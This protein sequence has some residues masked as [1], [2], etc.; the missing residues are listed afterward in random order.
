MRKQNITKLATLKIT[1]LP[2]FIH[3]FW[4]QQFGQKHSQ[5]TQTGTQVLSR[6]SC[7]VKDNLMCL[8]MHLVPSGENEIWR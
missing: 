6:T 7:V 3:S 1:N 5:E 4:W 2:S 8:E